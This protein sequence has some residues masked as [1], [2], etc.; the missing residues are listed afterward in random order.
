MQ[1]MTSEQA[2]FLLQNIYLGALKNESRITKK[3][4]ESVPPD[5]AEYKPEPNSRS[6]N[7]LARHIAVSYTH[8]T[9]PTI[10]SV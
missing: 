6:A 5:K 10:C 7:E 4:L 8:L 1:E 9:L 2:V 3:V